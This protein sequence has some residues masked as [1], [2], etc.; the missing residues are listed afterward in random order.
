MTDDTPPSNM[1]F[2]A[3]DRTVASALHGYKGHLGGVSM[4]NVFQTLQQKTAF[5]QLAKCRAGRRVCGHHH[6]RA[7]R[8]SNQAIMTV[9]KVHGLHA[10]RSS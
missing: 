7:R 1:G 6:Y 3:L 8:K 5:A 2:Y 9:S 4:F 10:V